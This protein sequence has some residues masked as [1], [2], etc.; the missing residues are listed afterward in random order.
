MTATMD[1]RSEL[2]RLLKELR[3]PTFRECFEEFAGEARKESLTYERYLLE[4]AQR[5]C[6]DRRHRCVERSLRESCLPLEKTMDVFDL[7]RLPGKVIRQ[8]NHLLEGCFLDRN[9]NVL[10]FGNPGSGKTHL[11]CAVARE[12]VHLGRR[13]YFA[14][15]GHLVQQL[16]IAKRDL[17]LE[18]ALKK[19]GKFAALVI[20]DIGYVQQDRRE[21]EVLFTLLA[22]RYER[23]SVMITGNLPFSKW[24][25][26]FKDPMTTA[27][28][29]DRVV[30]H[31]VI[32]ELNIP[33]Y[34]ME[35]ARKRKTSK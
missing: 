8:V 26:I 6:E 3:L 18:R 24:E 28:A 29:I 13:V 32:L 21:I 1:T 17:K 20:D 19:L 16:L 22:E 34:R 12:V 35:E 5:E 30:H 7:K 9:E 25:K 11:L 4:L 31:S 27:A 15:C 23:G 2:T 10:A 14:K 33:S